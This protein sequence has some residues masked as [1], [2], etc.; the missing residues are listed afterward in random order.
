[1]IPWLI[2]GAEAV[3]AF[4]VMHFVKGKKRERK[5]LIGLVGLVVLG[6]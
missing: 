5:I 4:S 1:M 6:S 3:A 2:V